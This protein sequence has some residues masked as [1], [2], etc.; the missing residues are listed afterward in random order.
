MC[1][2]I[3]STKS[4]GKISHSTKFSTRYCHKYTQIFT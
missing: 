3:L 1:V 2:L 4:A